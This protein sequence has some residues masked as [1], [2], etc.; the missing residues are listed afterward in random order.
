MRSA[1]KRATWARRSLP[2]RAGIVLRSRWCLWVGGGRRRQSVVKVSVSRVIVAAVETVG[3]LPPTPVLGMSW[4]S[5]LR[6]RPSARPSRGASTVESAPVFPRTWTRPARRRLG[7][8]LVAI[9]TPPPWGPA[10]GAAHHREGSIRRS[11]FEDT[12]SIKTCPRGSPRGSRA[13]RRVGNRVAMPT[14]C[15]LSTAIQRS[16]SRCRNAWRCCAQ[17]RASV[18]ER[19]RSGCPCMVSTSSPKSRTLRPHLPLRPLWPRRAWTTA[20]AAPPRPPADRRLARGRLLARPGGGHMHVQAASMARTRGQGG[21]TTR[22][23]GTSSCRTVWCVLR[24][25]RTLR[26]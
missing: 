6:S 13:C 17:D 7:R 25:C 9:T 15:W 4:G 10:D 16:G 11:V 22:H 12:C 3:V 19:A 26:R 1:T 18:R 21:R 20:G 24:R 14:T 2:R 5:P 8:V 23:Q